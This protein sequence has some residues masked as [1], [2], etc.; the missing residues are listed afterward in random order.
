[1]SAS[2]KLSSALQGRIRAPGDKSISH[3][4]IIL[5]A[6]AQGRTTVSGLLEGADILS[7]VGA[8]R[9]LGATVTR[10]GEGAW[11]VDGVGAAGLRAPDGLVDCGN[12]GTGVRLIMGAAAGYPIDVTYT[13]DESLRSRPMG[14]VLEPLAMMG[15]EADAQAGGRLPCTVHGTAAINA[16][17]YTPSKASAQVKSCVLLAGLR[18]QGKT[19][20]R[21]IKLTRDHTETM[22]R[23]FGVEVEVDDLAVSIEGPATLTATHIDVPGDPSSA[24][25]ATVAAL[26]VPGSDVVIEDVML[27]PRRTAL[28]DALISM[29][30]DITF[31]QEREVGGGERVADIRAR[32]SELQG[33]TVDPERA[34]DMIDEYPVLAV[35]AAFADGETHMNGIHELRVK[36]SDRISATVAL[37]ASNGVLVEERE[38]GMSVTGNAGAPVPGGATVT[39]HHDHRIAMSALVLGL[40]ATGGV[41]VDDA[42][43]IATSYPGFFTDMQALGAEVEVG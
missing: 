11:E 34:A 38:D 35:A 28:Y 22:L 36:E 3:R 17:D 7:T 32:H 24:A 15:V 19:T 4:S 6:L 40:R 37:L 29:G 1:M 5:G 14:R 20:V 21:E 9:A 2:S 42:S 26:I 43:M 8:M 12:A 13:G 30:A 33:I 41:S 10:T 25:F 23:A 27:N 39:T 18:A 31:E 16:V